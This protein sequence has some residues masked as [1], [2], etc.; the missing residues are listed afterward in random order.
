MAHIRQEFVLVFIRP[1]QLVRSRREH[2]VRLG[3]GVFL[4][5]EQ[6]GLLFE[7]RVDLLERRLLRLQIC[8]RFSQRPALLF[9][10]FIADAQ[11][12]LAGLK[13]FSLLLR[14]LQQFF[15]AP[16]ILGGTHRDG[17]G[18]GRARQQL[19]LV[20][21]GGTEESQFQ[22]RMHDPV[23][24]CRTTTNSFGV[25]VP[26]PDE[27]GRYPAGT[28][29]TRSVRLSRAACPTRPS[30]GRTASS[31]CAG[32]AKPANRQYWPASAM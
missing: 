9:E 12:L 21:I 16:A 28:S 11:L 5:F 23:N 27:I 26:I 24:A 25:P 32:S 17:D 20:G 22:H 2:V 7:L 14:F 3:Q 18:F 31:P 10:F 15:E 19:T 8:L 1:L 13:F 29:R 4:V 30:P 6:I